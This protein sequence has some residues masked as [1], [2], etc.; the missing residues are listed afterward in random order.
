MFDINDV[1]TKKAVDAAVKAA[2]DEATAGLIAKNQ[3]LLGKLKKATKDALIDPAEHQ[4]LQDELIKAND[5][6]AELAK[7][8]K[9][10]TDEADKMKKA[11][12]AEVGFSTKLIIDNGLTDSLVGAKVKPEMMKAVKALLSGQV[13]L[14][15]DGDKRVPVIGD[16]SLGEFVAEWS[17]TDEG[18]HFVAAPDNSGG[19][20]Q[21]GGDGKGSVK[22]MARAAFESLAADK[23]MAF[24]KEGGKVQ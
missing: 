15:A 9:K 8:T 3:E 2:V 24:I 14:K 21:G 23:Q 12:E 11:L 16:K 13:A 10:A 7:T 1:D 19:G 17:K 6:I 20:S 4:A 18:K 22:T 5:K